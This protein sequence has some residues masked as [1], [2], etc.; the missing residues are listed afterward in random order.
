MARIWRDGQK[1]R[2]HIYRLLATGTIDEKIFQRQVAKQGLGIAIDTT[3]T[4]SN[5]SSGSGKSEFSQEDLKDLFK[6]QPDTLSDTHDLLSCSCSAG[7]VDGVHAA[8]VAAGDGGGGGGASGTAGSAVLKSMKSTTAKAAKKA[9]AVDALMSWSHLGDSAGLDDG[10]L[11]SVT[12]T[13][14]VTF[15]MHKQTNTARPADT[16]I[17]SG[18]MR[19]AHSEDEEVDMPDVTHTTGNMVPA[20]SSES[21]AHQPSASA[22]NDDESSQLEPK[23]KRRWEARSIIESSDDDEIED[24]SAAAGEA[25]DMGIDRAAESTNFTADAEVREEVDLLSVFSDSD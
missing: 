7:N 23:P 13:T 16:G 11:Q 22:S 14:A 19:L 1:R 25:A 2:V 5:A 4:S 6:L 20:P 24:Q 15:V 21:R 17:P 18:D 3:K 8:A 12:P 9:K 10:L